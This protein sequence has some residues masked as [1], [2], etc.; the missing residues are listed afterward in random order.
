MANTE[1]TLKEAMS[2]IEGATG[3]ALVDYTSGMA[4]GTLG[5]GKDFNLEVAAAGNTDVIR[6]KLRTMEHL[7]LK[8]EIEDIL[9]TLNT[10]YHLI[11]LL[12]TR[13]GNG[14]FLYLVLDASRA[15]LA[16]A[17]HQLK[18]IEAELEV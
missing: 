5:G 11:R 9:I 6:A 12:K 2:S 7:G 1:A 13:G 8:E 15:N 16:M 18:K 3:A 17:R 10:Q 14:L 4:L